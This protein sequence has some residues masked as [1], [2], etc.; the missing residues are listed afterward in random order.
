MQYSEPTVSAEQ[1]DIAIALAW[2]QQ[3]KDIITMCMLNLLL[4]VPIAWPGL[5]LFLFRW[6]LVKKATT[7]ARVAILWSCTFCHEVLC[8]ML[9]ASMT[10]EDGFGVLSTYCTWGYGI[11][12]GLSALGLLEMMYR[13][14]AL[15]YR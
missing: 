7:P 10:R 11:G 13:S 3:S 5:V 1:S 4:V 2:L 9:F 6:A 15:Q 8:F 12:M 14:S